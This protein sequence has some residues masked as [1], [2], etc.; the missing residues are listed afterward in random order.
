M[1]RKTVIAKYKVALVIDIPAVLEGFVNG[2]GGQ[3]WMVQVLS[4]TAREKMKS[5]LS[6]R[7]GSACT[8]ATRST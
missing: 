6:G 7:N 4:N 8:S 5:M 3:E 2:F 1:V